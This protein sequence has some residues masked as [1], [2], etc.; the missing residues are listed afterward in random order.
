[1]ALVVILIRAGLDLDPPA[2]R[3]LKFTVL[4]LS[5]I[6][7]TVEAVTVAVLSRFLL[8]I[9]W[10]YSVLLGKSLILQLTNYLQVL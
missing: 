5:L 9:P 8:D 1:M 7:W 6:P 10:M 4:K 2:L 3:R